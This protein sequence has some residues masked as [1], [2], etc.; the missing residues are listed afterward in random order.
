[1]PRLVFY[2]LSLTVDTYGLSLAHR[3]KLLLQDEY[4][5]LVFYRY[6]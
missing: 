4:K 2:T 3:R 6:Q 1:M 5:F